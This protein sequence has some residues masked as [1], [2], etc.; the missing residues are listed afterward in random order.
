MMKVKSFVCLALTAVF[1]LGFLGNVVAQDL[2][3]VITAYNTALQTMRSDPAASVNSLKSCID[4]CGKIGAP[5][6]SIKTAANSKF[7][8]T[9]FNLGTKQAGAKDFTSAVENLKLAI[10]F[11]EK[12]NN[13]EVLKRSNGALAQ[14]YYIQADAAR[15]AKD[16]VKAQEL[17]GMSLAVDSTSSRAWIVQAFIYRDGDLAD[18]FEFAVAKVEETS[19]NANETKMAKQAAAKYFLGDGSKLVNGSKFP[20]AVAF[21]EKSM[22]YDDTSKDMLF[23]LAKAYNGTSQFDKG[24][25]IANKGIDLEEDVPEKEAKFWFEAGAAFAGKGDK[26]KACEAY[27]KAMFGQFAENAKY[28]IEVTLKCGK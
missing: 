5:A 3:E 22:K 14:I 2:T 13:A 19:K 6:D 16:L 15:T 26:T 4:L 20:E 21:L 18:N 25:E 11:G 24:L 8:E 17:I 9:Y 28:E 10:Q 27:K 7:A 12:T 23:F 1:S